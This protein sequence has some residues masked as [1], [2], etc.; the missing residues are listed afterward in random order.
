MG[1][2]A[3]K[4]KKRNEFFCGEG[5]GRDAPNLF[6]T[7][8]VGIPFVAAVPPKRNNELRRGPPNR[9]RTGPGG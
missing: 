2:R 9:C 4:P 3:A 7:V 1:R 5:R 8:Q 6:R